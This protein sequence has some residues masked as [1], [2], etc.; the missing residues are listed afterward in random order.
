MHSPLARS[1]AYLHTHTRLHS[2]LPHPP[3]CFPTSTFFPLSLPILCH[4]P[5]PDSG[6]YRRVCPHRSAYRVPIRSDAWRDTT[7]H[8]T[9]RRGARGEGFLPRRRP[10]SMPFVCLVGCRLTFAGHRCVCAQRPVDW[11]VDIAGAAGTVAHSRRLST[12]SLAFVAAHRACH[13]RLQ[14]IVFALLVGS[15]SPSSSPMLTHSRLTRTCSTRFLP[16]PR[17]SPY[18]APFHTTTTT[19]T[20]APSKKEAPPAKKGGKKVSRACEREAWRGVAAS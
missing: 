3:T 2:R 10:S 6:E 13:Y 19:T 5:L 18:R 8:D 15:P 1:H 4:H 12:R 16:F 17:V 9:T 14:D 11:R 20:M 7:R